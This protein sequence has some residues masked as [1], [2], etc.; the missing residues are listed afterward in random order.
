MCQSVSQCVELLVPAVFVVHI[1]LTHRQIGFV[2]TVFIP[3]SR[4]NIIWVGLLG[5]KVIKGVLLDETLRAEE[6][7]VRK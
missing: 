4:G 5:S 1:F 3:C 2:C 7:V 6:W